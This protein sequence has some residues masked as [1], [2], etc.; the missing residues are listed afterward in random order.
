L[1][2]LVLVLVLLFLQIPLPSPET[3]PLSQER[4]QGQE[5]AGFRRL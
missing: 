3:P 5:F 2:L 1:L 4:R